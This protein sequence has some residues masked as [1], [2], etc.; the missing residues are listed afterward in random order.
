MT[1]P[2]TTLIQ[3]IAAQLAAQAE[4]AGDKAT[5]RAFDKAAFKGGEVVS[6]GE[7]APPKAACAECGD[8][9]AE[10]NKDGLCPECHSIAIFDEEAERAEVQNRIR[11]IYGCD[12]IGNERIDDLPF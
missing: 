7:Q 3:E 10:L 2:P 8:V 12:F 5:R 6:G 1:L 4:Q 9:E 11:R